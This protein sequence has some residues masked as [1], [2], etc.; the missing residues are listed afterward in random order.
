MK[1]LALDTSSNGLS[2]AVMDNEKLLSEYF[3]TGSKKD[4]SRK[5]MPMIEEILKDVEVGVEDIDYYA[6]SIGPG[7]F[8]GLRIGITTVKGMAFA[9][10]KQV[11]GVN[12]LD[13]LA[14][15]IEY[16]GEIICPLID[17]KNNQ[18]YTAIYNKG[19]KIVNDNVILIN[20]L[21][22]KLKF[23]NSKIVFVG[24]GAALHEEYLR[25]ELQENCVIVNRADVLPVASS[26]AKVASDKIKKGETLNSED[27]EANY[28]R[29][30]QAER[31]YEKKYTS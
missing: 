30:S 10:D 8:T 23:L 9:N 26:V 3:I 21:T 18:V 14:G 28:L 15:T 7:S 2:V 4:H 6:V 1:I 20:E 31:E 22:D 27:L 19:Q 12:T 29:K 13:A 24:D 5:L 11:V 25:N 16:S 17:A